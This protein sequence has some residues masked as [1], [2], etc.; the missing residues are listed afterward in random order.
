MFS[1]M[2]RRRR[3]PRFQH[4]LGKPSNW[5]GL[6]RRAKARRELLQ[7]GT[8][9]LRLSARNPAARTTQRQWAAGQMRSSYITLRINVVGLCE[10]RI[11]MSSIEQNKAL[12]RRFYKEI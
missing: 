8:R 6:G 5:P 4:R 3:Y 10:R 1:R 12:V 7:L 11:A 2:N 9:R